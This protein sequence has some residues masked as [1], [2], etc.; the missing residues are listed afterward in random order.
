MKKLFAV[1]GAL[2]GWFA[3]IL[4]L[5]LSL[6]QA[7]SR[8]SEFIKYISFM[9]I[10]TNFIVALTLTFQIKPTE[11]KVSKFSRKP[12]VLGGVLVYI[13]VVALVYHL[14]LRSVWNPKGLEKIADEFLHTVVPVLYLLYW[15]FLF[16][17]ENLSFPS[18]FTG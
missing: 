5:Y 16:R 13:I 8:L 9:T 12:A 10:W 6:S 4:Q 3:L 11:S 1:T 15:I 14:I 7:D 17:K 2:A 18:V